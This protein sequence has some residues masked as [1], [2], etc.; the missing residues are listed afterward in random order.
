MPGGNPM[1]ETA[2]RDWPCSD[3]RRSQGRSSLH[4]GDEMCENSAD[5]EIGI[6]IIICTLINKL[7][8]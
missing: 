4:A 2:P 8:K 7:T 3:L 1:F 5:K 6:R